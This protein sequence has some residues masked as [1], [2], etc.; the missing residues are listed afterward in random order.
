MARTLT[1]D[2]VL[3]S[4]VRSVILLLLNGIIACRI[5]AIAAPIAADREGFG[6]PCLKTTSFQYL[7]AVDTRLATSCHLVAAK[8]DV[9]IESTTKMPSNG[10]SSVSASGRLRSF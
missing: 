5:L 1:I 2:A 9:I 4:V 7:R 3:E 8:A 10:L 6:I